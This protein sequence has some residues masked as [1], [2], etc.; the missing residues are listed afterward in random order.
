MEFSL[1]RLRRGFTLIEAAVTVALLGIV[2]G[3][4]AVSYQGLFMTAKEVVPQTVVV[5]VAGAVKQASVGRGGYVVDVEGLSVAASPAAVTLDASRGELEV[6]VGV[7][8]GGWL[9]VVVLRD[10][11]VCVGLVSAPLHSGGGQQEFASGSV[12]ECSAQEVLEEL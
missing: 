5:D 9:G 10:D 1:G 7:D 2:L 12:E 3:V 6:S 11:G 8:E 4:A